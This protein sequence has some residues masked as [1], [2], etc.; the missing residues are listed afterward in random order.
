METIGVQWGLRDYGMGPGMMWGW[1]G[2]G[3]IFMIIFWG[4]IIL[5]LIFFVRWL[6]RMAKTTQIEESA[7][8]ILKKRYARGEINKEEFE[9]KKKDLL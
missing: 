9:Q 3:W 1:W 8:D 2:M 5:G 4:L 6:V 7:L